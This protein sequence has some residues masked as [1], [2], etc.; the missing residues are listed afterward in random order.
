GADEIWISAATRE[1]QPVTMLD[2]APVGDGRPGPVWRRVHAEWEGYKRA[3][4][5]TPW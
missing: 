3:L 5:G 2:G 4:A 1:V